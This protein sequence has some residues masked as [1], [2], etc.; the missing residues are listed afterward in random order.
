METETAKWAIPHR[1]AELLNLREQL[2]GKK[3]DAVVRCVACGEQAEI[4]FS[5]DNMR[6]AF[7]DSRTE[8]NSVNHSRTMQIDG[9]RVRYRAPNSEDLA[10][11]C[12]VG[13]MAAA[14]SMLFERCIEFRG[15]MSGSANAALAERVLDRLS[16]E[17]GWTDTRVSFDCPGCGTTRQAPFDIASF[18]WREVDDWARRMLREIHLLA[19]RYGWSENDI[20]SMNARRRQAYVEMLEG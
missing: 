10:A 17:H 12:G 9:H 2:F 3:L 13:D 7:A 6:G 8:A 1:D 20:L 5:I 4:E 18:L 14:R 19:S 11:I 15:A 16:R